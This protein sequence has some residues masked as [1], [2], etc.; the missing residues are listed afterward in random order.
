MM[1]IDVIWR[2]PSVGGTCFRGLKGHALVEAIEKGKKKTWEMGSS[3]R[4]VVRKTW[5]QRTMSQQTTSNQHPQALLAFGA[6]SV[7]LM[8]CRVVS[9]RCETPGE[10][11]RAAAGR[12][13]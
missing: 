6:V 7:S 1:H 11:S 5:M 10:T 2:S 4:R 9:C 12:E 3:G 8:S 13:G